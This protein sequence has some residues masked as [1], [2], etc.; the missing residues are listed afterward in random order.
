ML[1]DWEAVLELANVLG[2]KK[3][4]NRASGEIGFALFLEGDIQ[5]ARQR[6]AGALIGATTLHDT[7]A[8]IRYLA[9]IG[10]GLV[11]VGSYGE[12]IEYFD[13]AL[14]VAP[15]N[16]DSGFQFLIYEGRL[17]ALKGMN[18]LDAAQQLAE[19]IITEARLHKKHVKETQALI[20]AS[21]IAVAQNHF[22]DAIEELQGAIN[23]ATSGG[24][25]RLLADAQFDLADIYRN[26]GDLP[27]AEATANAA[28][29]LTQTSGELYLLPNRLRSLAELKTSQGKYQAADA[30][31][32]RASYFIDSKRPLRQRHL[33]KPQSSAIHPISSCPLSPR[34]QLRT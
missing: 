1:R 29:A 11:L 31:Y 21:G 8:Q 16:P 6:V 20:T 24:F 23:L 25:Q 34:T 28:V 22:P 17:Q 27:K 32:D 5:T 2:N 26:A 12:A 15:G 3:W 4:Q 7:G 18:Q 9:A 30:T 13:K 19:K 10:T 14:N 33:L